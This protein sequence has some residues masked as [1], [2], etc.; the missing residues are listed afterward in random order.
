MENIFD[1]EN[2]KSYLSTDN[3]SELYESNSLIVEILLGL[4]ICLIMYIIILI[5]R[6]I[7]KK[8]KSHNEDSPVILSGLI[9]ADVG[10]I[11][12]QNPNSN[13]SLTLKRSINENGIEFTYSLWIY[14][15]GNTWETD[16]WKHVFHKGQSINLG[17]D[18]DGASPNEYCS[19]QCPGLWINPNNNSFR[20]YINTYNS[21][22]EF[23]DIDN[24]PVKKWINLTYTQS[25]FT[26]KVYINGRLK[27]SYVLRSLPRQ[28]YYN[29][30]L[31][32][33]NG[34]NGYVSTMKYFNFV[35]NT[36]TIYDISQK[37]PS[38]SRNIDV[39]YYDNKDSN[40][41]GSSIPYLS[42]RWWMDDLTRN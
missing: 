27:T 31:C 12:K 40:I 42:S 3:L 28:N 4:V 16:T 30:Y 19:I 5:Y 25:N 10:R 23:I 33:N 37:G 24:L 32:Q 38:L 26:S 9:D 6:S 34:F 17:L 20:L 39:T 22:N 18:K 36:G 14:I 11:V 21:I 1:M 35:L 41:L 13:N 7:K 8:V 2:I 29:L 15:K